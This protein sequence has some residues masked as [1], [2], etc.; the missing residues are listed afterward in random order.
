M[1]KNKPTAVYIP[2]APRRQ[3][4]PMYEMVDVEPHSQHSADRSQHYHENIIEH[5]EIGVQK[6]KTKSPTAGI[7]ELN[8][9]D[10]GANNRSGLTV[11]TA[12]GG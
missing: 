2:G 8:P 9:D 10:Y 1:I 5:E 7:K 4:P 11:S 3:H 6:P 12:T